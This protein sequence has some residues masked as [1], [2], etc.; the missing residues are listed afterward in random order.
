VDAYMVKRLVGMPGDTIRMSGYVLS[1]K[2]R[3]AAEFSSEQQ[4]AAESYAV[5]TD[6]QAPG[7]DAALPASGTLPE[8]VLGSDEYFVLGDNRPESSDSRS[9]GPV[10]RARII[11]KVVFRYWPPRSFGRL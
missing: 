5:V 3:G 7:W 8:R 6:A 4:G 10:G 11:G 9:W 1:V 2:P